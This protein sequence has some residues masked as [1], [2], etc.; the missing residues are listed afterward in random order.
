MNFNDSFNSLSFREGFKH[1]CQ[2]LEYLLQ[3]VQVASKKKVEQVPANDEVFDLAHLS[4]NEHK[5]FIPS[6]EILNVFE[7]LPPVVLVGE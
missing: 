1:K 4:T 6:F 7:L 2:T 3:N 5:K